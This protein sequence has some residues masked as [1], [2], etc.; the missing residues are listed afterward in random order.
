MSKAAPQRPAGT[1]RA[2]DRR[3]PPAPPPPAAPAPPAIEPFRPFPVDALPE[4]FRGL[5]NVGA[6]AIG[7]DA[8]YIAVPL[9]AAAA[10]AIGN[11]RRIELKGSWS[12]PP[13][14]WAA[15]IGESG[16]LKSPAIELA[17]RPVRNRQ[18]EAMAQHA[19]EM[20]QYQADL[21]NYDRDLASWRQP[22]NKN[23]GP[24]PTKPAEPIAWRSWTDDTTVEALAVLLRDQP[25]GLLMA[26]DELGGFLG[27][28]DQY[29][30]VRGSD[31]PKWLEMFGGRPMVWDR[32]SA[33]GPIDV[34]RAAVCIAGGIQPELL[35]LRLGREHVE[36]GLA[37]RFLL[38]YPPRQAKRWT[39]ADID[40]S[41]EAAVADVF[42]RLYHLQPGV[43]ANGNEEP[44][45]LPLT[46]DGKLT[47]IPFFND[48]A[49][50]QADLVGDL[51]AAWS[52]LEGY[53]AR[54]A[55][56]VHCVRAAAG[57][58][59][60][61]SLNSVD[62]ASIESGVAL[63]RW[64]GHEARR[65]YAVL[66][67]NE[68]ARDRRRLAE[69]VER[70]GGRMTPRDL[71]RSAPRKFGTAEAAE[72]ALQDLV[73][74]GFGRWVHDGAQTARE[75]S[76]QDVEPSESAQGPGLLDAVMSAF[77][78]WDPEVVGDQ[79]MGL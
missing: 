12:E 67:E 70:R 41:V 4:P 24:P 49:Q 29:K 6:Q 43:D 27:G 34:P 35:R 15:I 60:L 32:K 66:A 47:W 61:V 16:T 2:K 26:R 57:D 39:E 79:E 73:N 18:R 64:F 11:T 33:A 54:L 71:Q 77:A 40:Q 21:L 59:T 31:A 3:L 52:K 10:S 51:A 7:C 50:E 1:Q 58:P 76:A 28:F 53:A 30:Q 22:K 48:H 63:S 5:V 68:Q 20:Q 9:L 65:V 23:P 78:D 46:S 42:E 17:L 14:L 37:A 62:K 19:V 45:I 74:A 8:S 25:R 44:V 13:I 56:V 72:A 69:L 36:N 38:A 75:S 55:L